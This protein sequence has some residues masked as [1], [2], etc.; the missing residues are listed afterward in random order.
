MNK[1]QNIARL[2]NRWDHRA[3]FFTGEESWDPEAAQGRACN[4]REGQTV[5]EI[6]K[7]RREVTPEIFHETQ[8]TIIQEGK[9]PTL[10]KKTVTVFIERG[11]YSA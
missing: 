10:D 3:S 6:E 5:L 8:G 11:N 4:M 7:W 9:A 1:K 2:R